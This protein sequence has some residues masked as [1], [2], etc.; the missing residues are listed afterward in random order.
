[1]IRAGALTY[2]IFVLV[3]AAILCSLM[4]VLAFANRSYFFQINL[5]EQVKDKAYSA[6]AIGMSGESGVSPIEGASAK[7][8]SGFEMWFFDKD[9]V[10]LRAR[11]WGAYK[12]AYADAHT[13]GYRYQKG[14][15]FASSERKYSEMALYLSDFNR[16]LNVAGKALLKGELYLPEKGVESAYIEGSN[17][18]RDKLFYGT[19]HKSKEGLPSMDKNIK[20]YWKNYLK[21]EFGTFDSVAGY[22]ELLSNV[23]YSF[24][25]STLVATD[26]NPINLKY[27]NFSGNII[28]YSGTSISVDSSARLRDVIL[29]APKVIVGEG[30]NGNFH[31]IAADSAIIKNGVRMQ[32]PSSIIMLPGVSQKAQCLLQKG[33]RLN[34]LICS[35]SETKTKTNDVAVSIQEGSVFR[36]AVYCEDSFELRGTVEGQVFCNRILLKTRSGVYEN[37]LLDGKINRERLGDPIASFAFEKSETEVIP[38]SWF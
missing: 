19:K 26:V 1:M 28:F 7:K 2:A 6:L 27:G 25:K 22:Q 11:P 35:Y 4:I 37:H 31:I 29:V 34:G 5:N 12:V 33:S 3:V 14:V 16:P 23:V 32:A 18:S 38:V 15:F 24:S 21:G 20:Q 30:V 13:K 36:G 17:Y 8:F 10:S 9:T